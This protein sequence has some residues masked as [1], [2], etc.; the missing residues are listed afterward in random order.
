[1][2]LNIKYGVSTWL[3]T[4]PFTTESIQVL[5]PK[6]AGMGFDVVEIAVE[7]PALIDIKKVKAGL[8][9]YGLQVSICGAFGPS[10]DLT[11][12]SKQVQQ[13][14]IA[15]IESCLDICAE[16]GIEF[17]GG[18]MYSAVGKARMLKPDQRKA[19]W[20]LAVK[21]LHLVSEMAAARNLK[22]ALEPL[23]RFESDLVNTAD[24]VVRMVNDINHPAACVMLDSFHMSIEERDP[25][26]AIVTAGD[27]L[28]HLQVAENY[29]G[30]PGTG[31]TPWHAYRKGLERIGYE[32]IV[33]IES[34]T[35]DNVELAGAVCFWTAKAESQDAFATEG[36]HFLKKWAT[37]KI[38]YQ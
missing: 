15:Y 34:F 38:K 6:I 9:E 19:E 5:F 33:T 26:S 24:D 12:E 13:T 10:R 37:E 18:P 14:G 11:S 22:I 23:N 25:E 21:N 30:T 36:L 31:Q 35:T 27:K 1:M 28:I 29:R 4:S 17:L 3:W 16:L 8:N 2:A 20:D 32:G 7:D